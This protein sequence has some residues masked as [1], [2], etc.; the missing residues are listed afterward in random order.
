MRAGLS[1]SRCW[2]GSSR[3][4]SPTGSRGSGR[5][6]H[7]DSPRSCWWRRSGR[8]PRSRSSW[9][10]WRWRTGCRPTYQRLDL[11][12]TDAFGRA[13]Y[14]KG[15][16]L[17][18]VW[19]KE[20]RIFGL[21][22]WV[23]GRFAEQWRLV[24]AQLTAA[25]RVDSRTRITLL[26]AVV[27]VNARRVWRP[28]SAARSLARCGP[29]D[30]TVLVQGLLGVV[31]LADQEGDLLIG[32]GAGRVPDVIDV[33]RR[34]RLT[35][36]AATRYDGDCRSSRAYEIRFEGVRFCLSRQRRV[37]STTASTCGSR[38]GRS[39]AIVGL[40]GAGKT[41]LAKLL[42]GLEVPQAG[43]IT[44]DGDR[45]RS[46]SSPIRG[47]G[48]WRRSSRT[49][50][51][52]S[53]RLATTS[54]SARSSVARRRRRPARGR[55]ARREPAPSEILARLASRAGH[56]AVAAFAG[57]V[58]LSGGQWQRIALARAML[59]VRAGARVLILDEPTAHLDVRAE[60]DLYDRFLDLTRGPDHDR[61]QPPLLHRAPG[62]PDRRARRRPHHR[63]RQPR[64][65]WSPPA[66]NTPGCSASRRCATPSEVPMST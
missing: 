61:D 58:D 49:S 35:G 53:C 28:P 37:W 14:Y 10:G 52:T 48:P 5:V 45:P 36:D 16:A 27:A 50:S 63:G 34:G 7:R 47:G 42:A 60:A 38:P 51:T 39:L 2:R 65:N 43:R 55:G 44:V 57:G 19:A 18:P 12:D 64:A 29:G 15:L 9:C 33:E 1:A 26:V 13:A 66:V 17:M 6:R 11:V 20:L 8:L 30:V 32:W 23:S 21:V 3:A 62:R 24:M 46:T 25:R 22:D 54:D 4:I 31:L 40:N 41:T 59:A 56:A